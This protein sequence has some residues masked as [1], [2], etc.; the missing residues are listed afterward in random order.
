LDKI[1]Q[2]NESLR[3]E[4]ENNKFDSVDEEEIKKLRDEKNS[5]FE[6]LKS[7]IATMKQYE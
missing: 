5:L 7:A 1:S 4:L 6:K 3:L 2:E